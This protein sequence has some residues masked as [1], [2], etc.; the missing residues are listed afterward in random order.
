M[1]LERILQSQGFGSRKVCRALIRTGAVVVGG[2]PCDDPFAEFQAEDLEFSV[3]GESWRYRERA[4]LLL[5]KPAGYECSRSPRH[6][7]SVFAL[8][9]P[10]LA[11]RGVQS[12]GRLD[13]DT[14]GLLLLSDDGEFI[15]HLISPRRQ[16]TKI[17]EVTTKHPVS[18]EQIAALLAGVQLHDAP[19]PVSAASCVRVSEQVVHLG[20]NEG[21]YHQVK[22]ML[23]A[24][25]NRVAA[26]RR[27]Q[28]GGLL[29]PHDL[30]E[31]CWCWLEAT[32]LSCLGFSRETSA[33][34]G[35]TD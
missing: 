4:Y 34:E 21:K 24:C 1:Q 25:G 6:H 20:I 5:N 15:H 13:E 2:S 26:L 28:I 17:Y 29:L 18:E 27:I 14:T 7:P 16:I 9:P 12:V 31:G 32:D 23:A 11:L 35:L 19:E 30:A 33:P 3:A 22:R 8:L 10:P